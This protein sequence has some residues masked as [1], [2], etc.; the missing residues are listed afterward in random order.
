M[1]PR[2]GE[3][4]FSDADLAA[5]S[6]GLGIPGIADIHVHF[7]PPRVMA[8]VQQYFDAA[9]P[10]LG[11]EWPINYRGD[12]QE[13]LSQLTDLGVRRFA[14]LS[15][16]HRAGMADWL[17]QWQREFAV[18]VPEA[19]QTGTFFPETDVLT[20]TQNAVAN[21]V[22]VFKVHLQVGDFDPRDPILDPV[23]GFLAESA[24]PVIIH[25][26]SG[27][28]PGRFTGPDIFSEVM[29]D[30]PQLAAI[31]AHFGTPDESA[32]VAMVQQYPNMGLDT[33]MVDTDFMADIHRMPRSILPAVRELGLAGRVFFGSDF[34]NIPYAYAHQVEVIRRWDLGDDWLRAVLWGNAASLFSVGTVGSP[35]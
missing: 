19:I 18:A 14:G 25:A 2:G 26:G 29:R 35:G 11:L 20:Y 16:A 7:M 13:R 8:K 31:I 12:D 3:P 5:W 15:Y 21:G 9:G 30:H 10:L 24:I 1:T 4:Q 27:P 6:A 23:W 28:M 33:T 32:F 17:N 34:P 22:R